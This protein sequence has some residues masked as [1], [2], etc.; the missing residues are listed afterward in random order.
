LDAVLLKGVEDTEFAQGVG[1]RESLVAREASADL[2]Q[3]G[4]RGSRV[5][6]YEWGGPQRR[7]GGPSPDEASASGNPTQLHCTRQGLTTNFVCNFI[8][9]QPLRL[10]LQHS[11]DT[12]MQRTVAK[13]CRPEGRVDHG[14]VQERGPV[15]GRVP[16]APPGVG[17]QIDLD[18][19]GNPLQEGNR[20]EVAERGLV[21]A[22][23]LLAALQLAER[24]QGGEPEANVGKV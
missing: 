14:G 4:H 17:E 7:D 22:P 12:P 8:R 2:L 6:G 16:G 9:G 24:V 5:S 10:C 11:S 18:G 21:V 3:G 13:E 15:Q 20:D 23:R 1:E 19:G